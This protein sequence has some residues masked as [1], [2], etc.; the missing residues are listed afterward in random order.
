MLDVRFDVRRDRALQ[1]QLLHHLVVALKD[2]DGVPALL[3]LRQVVHGCLFDVRDR[4]L[5]GA[6]EGVHG[7]GLSILRRLNRRLGSL[8]DAVALQGGD[9]YHLTTQ[10]TG[11]LLCI[12]LIAVLPHDIHHVDGNDDR[13]TQLGQL[14]GQI[15]IALQIRAINNVEYGVGPL[16]D[17]IIARHHFLQRVWRERIDAGQIRN[18]D[19]RVLFE[20]AFLFLHGYAGP[21]ANKLVRSGQRIEQ[22]GLTAVWVARQRNLHFHRYLL[23]LR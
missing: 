10:R 18:G 1:L 4:M 14:R 5:N 2:L 3:F 22:C 13:N 12:D 19:I 21:V 8:H 9:L 20:L 15:Q 17:Q 23:P 11:Q 16:V 6:G 7:N